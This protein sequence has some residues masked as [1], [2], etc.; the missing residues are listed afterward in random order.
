[1]KRWLGCALILL[2][3][4]GDA[5]AGY[6]E[7]IAAAQ[8]CDSDVAQREL[9]EAAKRGDLDA[10][11]SL[12]LMG[13]G[14]S[15]HD[16]S[17]KHLQ[18][19]AL[20][21]NA[22]AKFWLAFAIGE[23][24]SHPDP[25]ALQKLISES[26]EGG[27]PP[28]MPPLGRLYA[29][30]RDPIRAYA[31]TNLALRRTEANLQLLPGG[32]E[33]WWQIQQERDEITRSLSTEELARAKDLTDE[34]DRQTPK[35]KLIVPEPCPHGLPPPPP[36]F[37]VPIVPPPKSDSAAQ[38]TPAFSITDLGTLGGRDSWGYAINDKGEVT[39]KSW[40]SGERGGWTR[41]FI[42]SPGGGMKGIQDGSGS[43][44]S[45][46]NVT[47][48]NAIN[49]RGS[50]TGGGASAGEWSGGHAI[51][52]QRERGVE[53]IGAI[54]SVGNAIND[55]GQVTGSTF[56]PSTKRTRAFVYIA[57]SG[58]T[59]IG[60]LGGSVS[61]GYGINDKGQVTGSSTYGGPQ[62]DP[63]SR[64]VP[65]A[66]IYTPGVGMKDIGGPAGQWSQGRAINDAGEVAG[67]LQ[68]NGSWHAFVY[69]PDR[70]LE[71]LGTLDGVSAEAWA[72]NSAT[73]IVGSSGGHAFLYS[74]GQ[75]MIDLNRTIPD[76]SGWVLTVARGINNRGEITGWGTINGAT[77]A[78]LLSPNPAPFRDASQ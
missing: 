3:L 61:A 30:R 73:Q 42:Y 14:A 9:S 27:Y 59:D 38:A 37:S 47:Y 41:A 24:A 28:A 21:G 39:G 55:R 23:T 74:R 43:D 65:H 63:R 64:R 20:A 13:N 45:G 31:W 50:I 52:Y 4:S 68:L 62:A 46:D 70:G 2:A 78:Y 17:L 60:T 22:G 8:R 77:H 12:L 25:T 66:F 76:R 35:S 75:G 58:M 5:T 19:A 69:T 40:L 54:G 49:N 10:E 67:A 53:D 15:S 1:M 71:D 51:L 26:A 33:G 48:G 11:V 34:L 72:I 36:K 57:E 44:Q 6:E 32:K 16:D 56:D 18:Q 29:D 7:G